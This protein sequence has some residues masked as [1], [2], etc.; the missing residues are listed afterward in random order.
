[1]VGISGLRGLIRTAKGTILD[2]VRNRSAPEIFLLLGFVFGVGFLVLTPPMQS[3]DEVEHFYRSYQVSQGKIFPERL[4]VKGHGETG[5]G[6]GGELPR[7]VVSAAV[8]LKGN[9]AGSAN[10]FDYSVLEQAAEIHLERHD[11]QQ[12]RFDNTTIYSP[13]PYIPQSIGIN[14]GKIFDMGPLYL[15]YLGRVFN[16]LFWLLA[17]YAAIRLVP[18]GKWAFA[19]IALNPISVFLASNLSSDVFTISTVALFVAAILH[20][21]QK[22]SVLTRKVLIL[23]LLTTMSVALLKNAYLPVILLLLA[24]PSKKFLLRYKLIIISGGFIL[25]MLWNIHSLSAAQTIPQ[26]FGLQGNIDSHQQVKYILD[27]PV[28]SAMVLLWNVFGTPS[29]LSLQSYNG[30]I[31]WG[32]VPLPFWVSLLS[33]FAIGMALL[34][35]D[36][37]KS[38]V[39]FVQTR[40]IRTWFGFVFA[41]SAAA[42]VLSLYVGWTAVGGKIVSGVQGRYFIPLSFLLVPLLANSGIWIDSEKQRFERFL[43]I[44]LAVSLGAALIVLTLRYTRGIWW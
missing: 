12:I 4:Y 19:A 27:E 41:A 36:K 8:L 17:T 1:M 30:I 9:V 25:G 34:S 28:R 14:I 29:I 13:V 22:E 7:S 44:I 23:L 42:I 39:R 37:P 26:Y 43:T 38:I 21:R 16:L 6:Y 35:M 18:V 32:D 11:T 5:D 10:K 2:G 3:P 31:G 24:I 33:F 20:L 15:I 40:L